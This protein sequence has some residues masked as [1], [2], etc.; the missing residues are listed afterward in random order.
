[1]DFLSFSVL[2]TTD[3]VTAFSDGAKVVG[4]VVGKGCCC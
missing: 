2:E 1:M 4:L 3:L